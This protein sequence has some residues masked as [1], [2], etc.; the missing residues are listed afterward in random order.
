MN[1]SFPL[2]MALKSFLQGPSTFFTLAIFCH[3][4]SSAWSTTRVSVLCSFSSIC[5]STSFLSSTFTFW[6]SGMFGVSYFPLLECLTSW[7]S[8]NT[9]VTQLEIKKHNLTCEVEVLFFDISFIATVWSSM[10]AVPLGAYL[11][12]DSLFSRCEEEENC[13]VKKK[14]KIK[15]DTIL[16][17]SLNLEE[18]LQ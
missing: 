14:Y 3:G 7:D 1:P 8:I 5:W 17:V 12:A 10:L 11:T 4:R 13:I 18:V 16:S 9:S 6:R 2:K 15:K